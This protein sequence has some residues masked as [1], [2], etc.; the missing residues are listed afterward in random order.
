[1]QKSQLAAILRSLSKDEYKEFGRFIHSPYFNNRDE[2]S[3]YYEALKEFYPLF[4]S[5]RLTEEIMFSKVY[6]G[7]NFSGLLMRKLNS[8]M[9]SQAM[10]FFAVSSFKENELEFNV[11]IL[12]RL[13]EKKLDAMFEKRSKYL[14]ELFSTHSNYRHKKTPS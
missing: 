4:S 6:P 9:I 8:L 11:K 12:D 14:N 2:V 7:K 13:R 3:R 10:N 1:M 5:K